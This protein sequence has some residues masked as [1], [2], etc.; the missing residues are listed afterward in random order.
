MTKQSRVIP[1]SSYDQSL[2]GTLSLI[3]LFYFSHPP[4]PDRLRLSFGEAL[5]RFPRFA[6]QILRTTG[7]AF[8]LAPLEDW[9]ALDLRP[10][11][12]WTP[13]EFTAEQVSLFVD[14]LQGLPGEPVIAASLTPVARGAMLGFSLSHAVADGYSLSQFLTCW[15]ERSARADLAGN[16]RPPTAPGDAFGTE[17]AEIADVHE[18]DE[19]ARFRL[20]RIRALKRCFSTLPFDRKRVESLRAELA[21]GDF[22]PSVNEALTAFLLHR[23]AGQIM[24]RSGNFRLRMPVDLRGF[25]PALPAD[26]IG[27]GFI[28]AVLPFDEA[29]DSPTAAA[30]T[31]QRVHLAIEEVRRRSHV[32]SL[33]I[34][35][36]GRV[37]F[38]LAAALAFDRRTDVVSTNLTK[39]RISDLDFGSGPPARFFC[40]MPAS[41]GFAIVRVA[42]GVDIHFLSE[43]GPVS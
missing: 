15:A 12:H 30:A 2:V 18:L 42:D 13:E 39:M 41:A 24:G 14:K 36:D 16:G 11:M 10:R 6:S 28:E 21:T 19:A 32:D 37:E 25:H 20:D 4:D 40:P 17:M 33:L 23:Y 8:A 1:L 9:P 31:A 34:V 27:N 5:A 26:Y 35:R 29:E 43:F 3:G 38:N 7:G 22:V